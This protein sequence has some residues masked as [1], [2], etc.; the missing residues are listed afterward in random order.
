MN[1]ENMRLSSIKNKRRELENWLAARDGLDSISLARWRLH[2]CLGQ[3]IQKY[4][5]SPLLDV[6][7][8]LAPFRRL[9]DTLDL[10]VTRL[11][12]ETR[13]ADVDIIGDVQ[14]MDMVADKSFATVLCTQVI[15]HV[16][17]PFGAVSEMARVLQPGGVL[18]LS[19]PH[20]SL[21]H[22]VP[23]DYWRF[24]RFG[25]L[26]LLRSA[27]LEV[28]SVTP[29]AGVFAFGGHLVSLAWMLTAGRLPGFRRVAWKINSILMVG[30]LG[31]V[32]RRFGAAEI[33]PCD[34]VA[35]ARKRKY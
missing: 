17:D 1:R 20:L 12:V 13:S 30:L 27:S 11:D 18:I 34:Y 2:A 3:E 19:A 24:T 32:D 26:Q 23:D 28:L 21:L 8:G 15:E 4:G 29:T 5:R 33:L 14:Q 16:P 35:V 7:A 9:C 22:E 6:G 31:Q 25:L 10:R